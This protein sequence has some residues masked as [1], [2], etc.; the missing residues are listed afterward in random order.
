SFVRER[1][2]SSLQDGLRMIFSRLAWASQKLDAAVVIGLV[3][4]GSILLD[5]RLGHQWPPRCQSGAHQR[6][7]GLYADQ[8]AR[9]GAAILNIAGSGKFSSDRTIAEYARE[10][11]GVEPCPIP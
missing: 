5:A 9:S 1:S 10:I 3:G 2:C 8:D 4:C 7:G 6:V 11:R